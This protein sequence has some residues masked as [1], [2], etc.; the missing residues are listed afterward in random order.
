M[1]KRRC[2]WRGGRAAP[3]CLPAAGG[4]RG[5]GSAA[6]ATP[7]G[8]RIRAAAAPGKHP[9]AMEADRRAD[10]GGGARGDPGG[11]SGG[12]RRRGARGGP[13]SAGSRRRRRSWRRPGGASGGGGRRAGAPLG[14][15]MGE[16]AAAPCLAHA[17]QG[18]S[19]EICRPRSRSF[20]AP[21][22]PG[23]SRRER[24]GEKEKGKRELR[25]G[26]GRRGEESG[27]KKNNKS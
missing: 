4:A 24:M 12:A 6:A 1:K 26:K 15:A 9:P 5:P 20:A 21:P 23:I 7:R 25:E 2:R 18:R 3:S 17:A 11:G 22:P 8:R 13:R 16:P 19:P 10:G 27:E 14:S